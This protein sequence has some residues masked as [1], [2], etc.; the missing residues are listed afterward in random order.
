MSTDQIPHQARIR[1]AEPPKARIRTF[2]ARRGRVSG[3]HEEGL[4]RFMPVYGIDGTVPF[5]A[6]KTYGR[7]A[8]LV[9]EIGSGMGD[10][11][12][13]MAEADPG[14][15]YLAVE[16][17]PPG[18]ANLLWLIEEKGLT[19]LRIFDGDALE[20]ARDA[21]PEDSLAAIHVYFPDPWPKPRHHKR[22][23]ISPE[24]VALLRSRLAVGGVVHCATD[25]VEYA[26]QML[27]VLTADPGLGNT[28]GDYTPRPEH[29]PMT[30]FEKR[31]VEAGRE[32]RDLVF[33]RVR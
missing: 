2:M 17:H 15:D 16:I 26:E 20:L 19:N 25:W 28:S 31:G 1:T 4:E 14:R 18:I 11:T 33:Q 7:R 9:L 30:K 24:R 5:D 32:I 23:I 21:L 3:R 13:A 8:P 27:E 10:A 12:A 22:R 29:R 6:E